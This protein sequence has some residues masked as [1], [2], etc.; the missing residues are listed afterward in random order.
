MVESCLGGGVGVAEVG[1]WQLTQNTVTVEQDLGHGWRGHI[2]LEEGGE[3]AVAG[4]HSLE[5]EEGSW[6]WP[7]TTRD[8]SRRQHRSR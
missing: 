6:R 7:H 5:A 1:L 8:W 4:H 2:S 3:E